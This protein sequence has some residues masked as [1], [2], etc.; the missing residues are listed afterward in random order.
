MASG[1]SVVGEGV[2]AA[3]SGCVVAGMCGSDEG[4]LSPSMTGI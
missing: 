3:I 1:H 4:T 2:H